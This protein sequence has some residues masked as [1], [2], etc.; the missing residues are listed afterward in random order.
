MEGKGDDRAFRCFTLVHNNRDLDHKLR[1]A[2]DAIDLAIRFVS[3][4][5]HEWW[6]GKFR[7]RQRCQV[8]VET[9][10]KWRAGHLDQKG[11]ARHASVFLDRHDL[12]CDTYQKER[13]HMVIIRIGE[14]FLRRLALTEKLRII[15]ICE[16]LAHLHD[17]ICFNEALDKDLAFA[18]G[19]HRPFLQHLHLGCK[20]APLQKD[21][22]PRV[23]ENFL[24]STIGRIF[25]KL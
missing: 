21:F 18:H 10:A 23:D 7:S 15:M 17:G 2:F 12:T 3:V 9:V 13:L 8:E 24:P 4:A 22:G 6:R 11:I 19:L 5:G 1:V 16:D 25:S 20:A 14:H